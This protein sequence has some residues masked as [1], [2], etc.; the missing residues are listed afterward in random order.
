MTTVVPFNL[1]D[2]SSG[3]FGLRNKLI[4]A[5]GDINQRGYVSGTATSGANQYTVDRWR[6][7]TSGQNLSWT[8]SG[9]DRAFT[10]PAG[11]VEQVVEASNIDT[12]TYALSWTGTATATVNGTS[13]ANG[14]TIA[15]TG[16]AT[17]TVKFSS[18]TFSLPQLEL[19]VVTPF[20]RRPYGLE[21]AL[22]QRYYFQTS[23]ARLV[24]AATSTSAVQF[25]VQCP[26]PMRT[27]PTAT[28]TVAG[29]MFTYNNG[30]INIT[31]ATYTAGSFDG[32]IVNLQI[33]GVTVTDGN[34]HWASMTAVKLSAEL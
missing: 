24:G 32:H 26:V 3:D 6:V 4:N 18:G 2:P 19:A 34:V 30:G 21:L 22:C 12:G 29:Q 13:V 16:G 23:Y 9:N 15:L 11:G 33:G 1:L 25:A 27:T 20:E 17:A 31:S 14:G 28:G 10:A 7:V 5:R 8:T